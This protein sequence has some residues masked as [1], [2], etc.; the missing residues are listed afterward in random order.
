MFT[1]GAHII[2][3]YSPTHDYPR[4]IEDR[5][6]APLGMTSST[7]SPRVVKDSGNL[8]QSWTA[9]SQ[10]IP[11]WYMDSAVDVVAGLGGIITNVV[12]LVCYLINCVIFSLN[13][14]SSPNG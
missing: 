13:I 10:R 5:I 8:T 12:D 3:E 11:F 6:F 9:H 14:N 7:F 4:F 1:T 2:K